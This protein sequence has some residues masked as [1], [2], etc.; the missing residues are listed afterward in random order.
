MFAGTTPKELTQDYIKG[1][2]DIY[3]AKAARW[4]YTIENKPLS[5]GY[6]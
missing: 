4:V 5:E 3:S 6:S 2:N 1:N